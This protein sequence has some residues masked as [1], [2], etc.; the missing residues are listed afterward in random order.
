MGDRCYVSIEFSKKDWDTANMIL[1]EYYGKDW[2]DSLEES[3]L[4]SVQA[5]LHNVS[6]GFFEGMEI[7]TNAGIP[8]IGYNAD[9]GDYAAAHTVSANKQMIEVITYRKD[10]SPAVDIQS[11]GTVNELSLT[12]AHLYQRLREQLEIYIY[13]DEEQD[14]SWLT[15]LGDQKNT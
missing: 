2:Y 5:E 11:D 4:N 3:P 9:G 14:F 15:E 13:Q 6:F 1:S 7:L 12:R 8:F 10:S